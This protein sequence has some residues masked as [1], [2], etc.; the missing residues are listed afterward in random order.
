M[1]RKNFC[2]IIDAS[3]ANPLLFNSIKFSDRTIFEYTVITLAPVGA[4]QMEMAELGVECF[5]LNHVSRKQSFSSFLKVLSFFRRSGTQIVQTH[6]MDAS[7]IGLA[8]AR[9]AGVPVRI[10]SG[11]HSAE[12]ALSGRALLKFVDGFSPRFLSNHVIAPSEQMKDLFI[13]KFGV[14][15]AK[16]SVI[17]HGFDLG[18]IRNEAERSS[19]IREQLAIKG[20]TILLSAGRLNWIK[21]FETMIGGFEIAAA[22]VTDLVLLIAGHGDRAAIEKLIETKR[23]AEKV[24][25]LGPRT[26]LASIMKECDVF[27]HTSLAESFGMVYIEAFALSKPVI[28][29]PTGVAAE[30]VKDG[31]NGYFFEAG[32]A[33][34][35]AAAIGKILEM[36]NKWPDMG[37]LGRMAAENFDVRKTQAI[38]DKHS[39]QWLGNR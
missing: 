22:G 35:F 28:C 37:K 11:H 16:I 3:T 27:V 1:P 23:L 33:A 34:S 38:C 8:A 20:K 4:L 31:V 18:A 39:L 21:D 5:S 13:R 17:P 36:R 19:N 15:S 2:H 32:N 9:V 10:F 29:T 7:I 12:T 14:R 30:I 24:F 25:M 26:D 6:L